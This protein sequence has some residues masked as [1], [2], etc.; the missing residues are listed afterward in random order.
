M[1]YKQN[2]ERGDVVAGLPGV[3]TAVAV[4]FGHNVECYCLSFEIVEAKH[5]H[6]VD[7]RVQHPD[8]DYPLAG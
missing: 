6:T 4:V 8:G 3:P 5:L 1:A 2:M 7:K